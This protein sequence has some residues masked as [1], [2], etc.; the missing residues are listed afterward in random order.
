MNWTGAGVVDKVTTAADR[1]DQ[2]EV[3]TLFTA[4]ARIS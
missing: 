1:L 2:P 4:R 3:L